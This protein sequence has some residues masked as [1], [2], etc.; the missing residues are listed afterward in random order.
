[1]VKGE[2]REAT[3]RG[4]PLTHRFKYIFFHGL[5]CFRSSACSEK[6][7]RVSAKESTVGENM[8][9]NMYAQVQMATSGRAH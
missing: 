2:R 7:P 6:S 3:F 8:Y 5:L 4:E 9:E 1:M